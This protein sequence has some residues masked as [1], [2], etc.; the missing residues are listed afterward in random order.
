MEPW[1]R[2]QKIGAGPPF[3]WVDSVEEGKRKLPQI[4]LH[5][6]CKRVSLASGLYSVLLHAV[7]M[8]EWFFRLRYGEW[9]GE[10]SKS[11]FCPEAEPI[12]IPRSFYTTFVQ[13]VMF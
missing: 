2:K 5:Y 13:I 1:R 8:A 6:S 10:I 4:F 9:R 11:E 3:V 12:V 7:L